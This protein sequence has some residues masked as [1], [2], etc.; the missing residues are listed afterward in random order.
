M[1]KTSKCVSHI[2]EMCESYFRKK[3][4]YKIV[5]CLCTKM[6]KNFI[7]DA[8]AKS[9]LRKTSFYTHITDIHEQSGKSCMS[10]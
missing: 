10:V 1:K 3:A 8:S 2:L 5:H 6:G 4:K 9:F 7:C